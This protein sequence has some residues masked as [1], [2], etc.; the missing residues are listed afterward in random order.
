MLILVIENGF[1]E[2]QAY[3]NT[4]FFKKLSSCKRNCHLSNCDASG[5]LMQ[6]LRGTENNQTK[7]SYR[8]LGMKGSQ[9]DLKGF[10]WRVHI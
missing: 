7:L 10:M 2:T 8:H 5:R 9:A 1:H 3:G 6:H 4:A